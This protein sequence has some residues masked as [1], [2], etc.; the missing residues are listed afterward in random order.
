MSIKAQK[1]EFLNPPKFNQNDL[2]KEKSSLD[3]N[4]P[5]EILYQSSSFMIDAKTELKKDI[6]QE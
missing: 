6:F 1:H 2:S 5:A 4:A 3:P